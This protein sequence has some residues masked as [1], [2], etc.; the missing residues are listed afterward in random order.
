MEL[1]AGARLDR[2][3]LV[4]SLGEGG[5]A[6]VWKVI[7]PLE[8]GAVRAL[9]IYQLRGVSAENAERARREAKAVA[10]SRHPG[11]LPCRTLIED[12][13][14]ALLA[15]VFDY[16]RGQ[17]LA[18]ALSDARMTPDLRRAALWQVAEALA[19]V[20]GRGVVH[21]DVKPD[22]ILVTDA[23][24]GSPEEAGTLKL[25]DFGIAAPAGNPRPLTREGGVVGTAPYLPPE[26]VEPSGLFQEGSDFQRDVFA[27]GVLGWEVLVGGH[28]T[29]LPFGASRDAFAG[30]YLSARAGRRAWPPEAPA[31]P[32]MEVVRACLSLAAGGRPES[33]IA[34]ASALRTRV[35]QSGRP[36]TS[37]PVISSPGSARPSRTE[38]HVPPPA[39]TIGEGRYPPAPSSPL[40]AGLP[41]A[42]HVHSRPAAHPHAAAHPSTAAHPRGAAY[43]HTAGHAPARDASVRPAV[44]VGAMLFGGLLV[45][46]AAVGT[47]VYLAMRT[48]EASG[49]AAPA[50]PSEVRP[51]QLPEARQAAC[52]TSESGTCLSGRACR[53]PPCETLGDAWWRLRVVG[54]FLRIGGGTTEIQREWRSSSICLRNTRTGEE[55]CASSYLMW[56]K[57][58]DAG[59][60]IA[61]TTTDLVQGNL[62]VHVLDGGIERQPRIRA[63]G[64]PV[65]YKAT[66]LCSKVILHLGRPDPDDGQIAVFLDDP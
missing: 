16:V 61:A 13:E 58:S 64:S 35:F 31:S 1:R 44:V 24:W 15:L 29:G 22:N 56:T 5:Q 42:G 63:F 26:I 30:I 43:P 55:M 47:G 41:G 2:Y 53:Q 28:P 3:T 46:G 50:R 57:G 6:V 66:A 25:V 48:P 49:E 54:G 36:R 10:G 33:C 8:G 59:N 62:E 20:H 12:P 52:C 38:I 65:G 23:F 45:L 21:R 34:V 11:I 4:S 18:D 39:D 17:S 19:Y 37:E 14:N 40:S 51:A 32:E 27:F 60:R 9:K 7:D